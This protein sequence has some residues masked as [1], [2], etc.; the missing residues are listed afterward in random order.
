[1]GKHLELKVPNLV[2]PECS[3]FKPEVPDTIPLEFSGEDMVMTDSCLSETTG[4]EGGDAIKLCNWLL[5]FGRTS[6]EFRE[7]IV[8]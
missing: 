1:M 6:Q 8:K 7:E 5:G 3:S 2:N 4:E